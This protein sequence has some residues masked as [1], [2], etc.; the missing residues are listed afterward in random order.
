MLRRLY[1]WTM[2]LA[3][4]RRAPAALAAV[5][6]AESSFFP[7]PPDVMLIPMIIARRERAFAYAPLATLASLDGGL[8]G[9]AIGYGLFEAVGRP[10]LQ[11]YGKVDEFAGFTEL[12]AE[13]GVW[14][15]VIK[16]MTPIPYKII[17]IAAGVAQMPLPAFILAS[18]V[19]RAMRFFIVA[20]LLYFFG[21]PIRAFVEKRLALVTSAFLVLLVGGFVAV[22]YIF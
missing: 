7:I 14:I 11:F 10:I 15:I 17:T 3:A 2:T 1:N 6:F 22:R 5:S 8:F 19:A 21:E 16:G 13:Y 18:I 12:F 9:Y 20:V 4:G